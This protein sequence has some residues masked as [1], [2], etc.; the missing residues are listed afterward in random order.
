[1]VEEENQQELLFKFSMYEK[2]IRELQQQIE[3]IDRG[4]IELNSLNLGLDELVGSK[5]KEIYA[6]LG[7]GIFVKAKLISEELNVDVGEGNI[8][9]KSIPD[10][11]ELI[12]EQVEK[13]T[14][15]KKE[16]E[17]NFEQLGEEITAMMNDAQAHEH[18]CNCGHN[19]DEGCEC[20][21]D[22]QCEKEED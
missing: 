16:L 17:N 7:K 20:G 18:S 21:E 13:L 19:H 12:R 14:Q 4:I 9:K 2:Q 15:V 6:P 10:T 3:S 1:M 5:D 22:C 8:V 11:K